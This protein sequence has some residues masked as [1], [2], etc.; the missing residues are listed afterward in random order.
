MYD[1]IVPR[2][3]VIPLPYPSSP[4][5]ILFLPDSSQLFSAGGG[6]IRYSVDAQGIAENAIVNIPGGSL[7]SDGKLLYVSETGA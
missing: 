5:S 7:S 6:V 1:G 2:E 3:K 4:A